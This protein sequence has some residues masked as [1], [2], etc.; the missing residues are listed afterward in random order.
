MFGGDSSIDAASASSGGGGSAAGYGSGLVGGVLDAVI[1]PVM[2]NVQKGWSNRSARKAREWAEY[3]ASTQYQRT[4]KDLV[5]AGLNPILAVKGMDPSSGGNVQAATPSMPSSNISASLERGVSS[6]KQMGLL[7]TQAE[8]LKQDLIKARNEAEASGVLTRKA[9]AE[10][11]EI[12]SRQGLN[13]T[14]MQTNAAMLP[15]HRASASEKI[16]NEAHLRNKIYMERV[17]LPWSQEQ[18][19]W[20]KGSPVGEISRAIKDSV[21]SGAKPILDYREDVLRRRREG[22]FYDE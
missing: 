17:G 5:A 19:D 20:A 7:G 18:K 15:V 2:A 11:G 4:T 6:G 1:G 21:R 16:A 9:N 3:M 12:L 14:A 22:G 10:V 13:D 8:I